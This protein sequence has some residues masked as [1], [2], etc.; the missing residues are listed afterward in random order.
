MSVRTEGLEKNAQ[1]R[2][3]TPAASLHASAALRL[4]SSGFIF[5]SAEFYVHSRTATFQV[6]DVGEVDR[7]SRMGAAGAAG[8]SWVLQ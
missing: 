4:L 6:A 5:A 1:T 7:V 8:F 3:W 2:R